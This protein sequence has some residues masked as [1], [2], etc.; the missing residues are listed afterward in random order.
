MNFISDRT[1]CFFGTIDIKTTFRGTEAVLID[2][3]LSILSAKYYF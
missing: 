1:R 2:R 3:P